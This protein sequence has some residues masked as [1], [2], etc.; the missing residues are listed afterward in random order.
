MKSGTTHPNTAQ[1][2]YFHISPV[3]NGASACLGR[4][5]PKPRAGL[6]GVSPVRRSS[7]LASMVEAC[8]GAATGTVA[9]PV[10]G[11]TPVSTFHAFRN[12]WPQTRLDKDRCADGKGVR[13]WGAREGD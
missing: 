6:A 4:R 11:V 9:S 7:L 1:N 10:G 5:G 8:G 13:T 2:R 12:L 3:G